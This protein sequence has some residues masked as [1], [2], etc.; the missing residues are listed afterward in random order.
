MRMVEENE[1]RIFTIPLRDVKRVPRYQRANVAIRL[2][3]KYISRHMKVD[4]ND[5]EEFYMEDRVN[6]RIWS[7]GAQKPPSKIRVQATK[8]EDGKVEIILLDDMT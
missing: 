1:E 7:R 8:Y 6:E 5:P 4:A 2:V 3:R